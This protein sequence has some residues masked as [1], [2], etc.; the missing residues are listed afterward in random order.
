[1]PLPGRIFWTLT[2]TA[3]RWN[4]HPADVVAWA[5]EGHL[6]LSAV[7][8]LIACGDRILD[9]WLEIAAADV[10]PLFRRWGPGPRW[11]PIRRV[12]AADTP[13]WLFVTDPAEGIPLEAADVVILA[14]ELDRFERDHEVFRRPHAGRGPETRYDWEGALAHLV[15]RVFLDG[16]P[17]SQNALVAELADWFAQR[18][19]TGDH[20]DER[21]IRRRITP[22]WRKLRGEEEPGSSA[23]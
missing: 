2:E 7:L 12:R 10:M 11:V 6:R 16:L 19:H 23:S 4:C 18:S 9:G 14:D 8:P 17:A 22:I 21:T 15:V 3:A 1:M 5:T 20:P 13:D